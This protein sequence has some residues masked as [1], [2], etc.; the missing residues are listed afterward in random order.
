MKPYRTYLFDLYGTLVDIHTNESRPA[1]WRQTA[2]VF[3]RD[4]AC[5]SGR[6]LR[7]A[8]L[9]ACRSETDQLASR[10]PAGTLV[11]PDLRKVFAALYL[12]KGREAAPELVE[13]TALAF[14]RL[15]TTH[16][17]AYA[18]AAELLQALRD[19][20]REVVLLSNAQRCF[21]EPELRK[22]GLWDCFDRIFLSSDL[23]V[24]KPDPGIFSKALEALGREP[25]D[26]LM[27][28]NDPVCDVGGAV[29]VGIDAVYVH[30][31]LSPR[32]APGPDWKAAKY[33]LPRMD[34]RRLARLLLSE[35]EL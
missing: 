24:Q 20:G 21:T 25:A 28:G 29:S 16:L 27:I 26:C 9:K 11:E 17:R 4:G 18:G 3:T 5:Y 19:R 22:L 23:G 14:R 15:S 35:T 32:P 8:Y 30:S 31:G 2:D 7:A 6:E 10:A 13:R 1:F 33:R 12:A 34:L